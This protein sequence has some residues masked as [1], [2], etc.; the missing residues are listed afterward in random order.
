MQSNSSKNE[1]I[2]LLAIL[3]G[4]KRIFISL[5]L[6]FIH[7]IGIV[8]KRWLIFLLFSILGASAGY[9]LYRYLRPVY[10]SSLSLS[11]SILS[12]DYC[13]DMIENLSEIVK[14]GTPDLLAKRLNIEIPA[15]KEIKRIEFSNF[16]EK[17]NKMYEDR[18]TIVL[19]IPFKIIVYSYSN[20]VFETVEAALV[21]YLENNKYALKR[22]EIK[23]QNLEALRG[24]LNSELIQLDTLKKNLSAN[25]LPRGTTSGFVFGQPIDPINVY[26]AGIEM[27]RNDLNVREDILLIDGIQVVDSFSPRDKPDSPKLWKMIG[28]CVS[29]MLFFAFMLSY[30]LERK[31]T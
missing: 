15:A 12:N 7:C 27:F 6:F 24:K 26:K 20:T 5:F 16:N 30:R 2:D 8:Q 11:S 3:N 29:L 31:K 13:A 4:I 9:G 10:V 22:K 21:S 18:D 14:D 23:K 25:I 1:E 17:L 28:A 19:G